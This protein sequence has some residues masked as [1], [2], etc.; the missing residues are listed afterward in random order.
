MPA[1]QLYGSSSLTESPSSQIGLCLC[2]VVKNQP[3]QECLELTPAQSEE[4]QELNQRVGFMEAWLRGRALNK[5]RDGP[6]SCGAVTCKEGVW[7]EGYKRSPRSPGA[8]VWLFNFSLLLDIKE[9]T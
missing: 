5:V 8:A 6:Q 2:E 9:E 1:G 4:Q 7:I 3:A